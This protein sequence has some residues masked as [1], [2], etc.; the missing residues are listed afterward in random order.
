MIVWLL[1]AGIGFFV[2][3]RPRTPLL[4]W[5]ASALLD[6]WARESVRRCLIYGNSFA[7]WKDTPSGRRMVFLDTPGHNDTKSV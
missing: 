1:L 4:W 6:R 2:F 5:E 7:E 3:A